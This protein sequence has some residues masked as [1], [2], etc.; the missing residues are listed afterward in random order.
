MQQVE[1][2]TQA[3]K[4]A[5]RGSKITFALA[6]F[7]NRFTHADYV[8]LARS[9]LILKTGRD[10]EKTVGQWNSGKSARGEGARG[11]GNHADN[12]T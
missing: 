6:S 7:L 4:E 5:G 2:V 9:D 3:R 8:W 10:N 12:Y 11:G 1:V